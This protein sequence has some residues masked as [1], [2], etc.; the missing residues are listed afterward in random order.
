M[1]FPLQH[2]LEDRGVIS[3]AYSGIFPDGGL[4][5]FCKGGRLSTCWGLK[6]PGN[7]DTGGTEHPQ[8]PPPLMNTPL[9]VIKAQNTFFL[10]CKIK[11]IKKVKKK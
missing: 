4:H 6:T 11:R 7:P 1:F 2:D 8:Q 10:E 9:G 5:F 3:W